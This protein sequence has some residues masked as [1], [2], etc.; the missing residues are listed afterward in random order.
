MNRAYY[1]ATIKDFLDT[2]S[3]AILGVWQNT[4][5]SLLS[6]HKEMRGLLK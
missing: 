2:S 4:I 6:I 5:H 1:S 3:E